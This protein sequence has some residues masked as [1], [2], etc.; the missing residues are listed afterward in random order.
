MPRVLFENPHIKDVGQAAIAWIAPP[1]DVTEWISLEECG[2]F[3]C[4]ALLNV[5]IHVTGATQQDSWT[6]WSGMF[7][8][9]SAPSQYG[10]IAGNEAFETHLADVVTE[11]TEITAWN[12][13]FCDNDNKWGILTFESDD[14]DAEDRAL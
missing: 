4:S 5:L 10:L 2:D 13:Y 7:T 3:P 8:I 1:N 14:D 9:V 12:G 6:G 11:C